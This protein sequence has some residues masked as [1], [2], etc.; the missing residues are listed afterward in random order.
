[1]TTQIHNTTSL[2]YRW[3]IFRQNAAG[4][5]YALAWVARL[6]LLASLL[7]AGIVATG[8]LLAVGGR[9]R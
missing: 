2:R 6:A 5:L 1:M 7:A 3:L 8:Y 4:A 9:L